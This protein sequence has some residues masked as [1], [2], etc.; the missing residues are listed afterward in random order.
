[1]VGQVLRLT[2]GL[3][4]SC[5]TGLYWPRLNKRNL[6]LHGPLGMLAGKLVLIGKGAGI[7]HTSLRG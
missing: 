1:M 3:G 7:L 4:K 5:S 2:V 6:T